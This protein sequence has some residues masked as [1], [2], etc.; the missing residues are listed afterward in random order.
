MKRE[1]IRPGILKE[2]KK[3]LLGKRQILINPGESDIKHALKTVQKSCRRYL[4]NEIDVLAAWNKFINDF[5]PSV[6]LGIIKCP[7]NYGFNMEGTL[8][9]AVK[10][11]PNLIGVVI[12]RELAIPGQ[13]TQ[14]PVSVGL[15][16]PKRWL[17]E[18]ISTFWTHLTDQEIQELNH[19]ALAIVMSSNLDDSEINSHILKRRQLQLQALINNATPQYISEYQSMAKTISNELFLGDKHSIS[20]SHFQKKWPSFSARYKRKLIPIIHNGQILVS[21]LSEGHPKYELNLDLWTG[22]QKTFPQP[23]ILFRI[24]A[25]ELFKEIVTK[26]DA[27]ASLIHY[28]KAQ[29][30]I[31]HH[32]VT[33]NTVGWIIVHQDDSNKI[34]FIDEIQSDVLETLYEKKQANPQ[35][36][37]TAELIKQLSDWS[38]H[39]FNSVQEWA[40]S[41]GY[42]TAIHSKESAT[43]SKTRGMT[44]SERKWQIYY[45]TI[46]HHFKLRLELIPNY[47][48]KIFINSLNES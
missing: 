40:T 14:A 22:A 28:L 13:S 16:M 26:S 29:S 41:I 48:D 24:T 1:F 47:P 45:R 7:R 9:Q 36:K 31:S 23:Q 15:N 33:T 12:G 42:R 11:L 2:L 46:T 30:E 21:Q 10:L 3:E 43:A 35:E 4:L 18:V 34:C 20:W 39:G 8:F 32:P 19:K 38:T 5:S 37:L 17:N 6:S 25:S 27:H 44:P